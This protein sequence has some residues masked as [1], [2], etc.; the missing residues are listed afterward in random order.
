[1]SS[2]PFERVVKRGQM[3][4]VHKT[5]PYNGSRELYPKQGRPAII[6]SR[7]E[8]NFMSGTVMVAYLTSEKNIKFMRDTQFKISTGRVA[9]SVGKCEQIDTVDKQCLGDYIGDLCNPDTD[10]MD[11]SLLI[12]LGIDEERVCALFHIS[13]DEADKRQADMKSEMDALKAQLLEMEAYNTSLK[14]SLSNATS[15][16]DYREEAE[17]YKQMYKDLLK[18]LA[19]KEI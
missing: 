16:V 10:H 1:M 6:V 12:A 8:E 3:Y 2:V 13:K 17:R 15:S 14:K 5:P 18:T 11:M 19:G 7:D 9:R 4:Y